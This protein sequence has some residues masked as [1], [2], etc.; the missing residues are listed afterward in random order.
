MYRGFQASLECGRSEGMGPCAQ[1]R[2]ED[3]ADS[4]THVA[5]AASLT[6]SPTRPFLPSR[7]QVPSVTS[8]TER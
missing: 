7:L 4:R 6:E 2:A 3:S 8:H 5:E 1:A